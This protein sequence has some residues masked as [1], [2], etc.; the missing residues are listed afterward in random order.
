MI[1]TYEK[2]SLF[3]RYMI[4]GLSASCTELAVLFVLTEYA[5]FKY[6][7]SLVVAV[8][9]SFS[10][11]FL[12]QKYFA[13]K[14]PGVHKIKREL[15]VYSMLYLFTVGSN[16]LLLY[17]AVEAI[18]LPYMISQVGIIIILACISF[19]VYKKW[20]FPKGVGEKVEQPIKASLTH[21]PRQ[22]L[23][24]YYGRFP[25][26]KAASLFAAKSAESFADRGMPTTLIV[27]GG[28]GYKAAQSIEDPFVYFGV[29][30]NLT[31]Q[32]IKALRLA[33]LLGSSYRILSRAAFLMAYLSYAL[34]AVL[35]LLKEQRAGRVH[36]TTILYSNEWLVL[37]FLSFF[38]EGTLLYEMHDFPGSSISVFRLCLRRIPL[39]LIHNSWKAHEAE[40][41][42]GIQ[43]DA[44]CIRSNPADV[45]AFDIAMSKEEARNRLNLPVDAYTVV[46]T[47][48]LF[49][50]KGVYTA[51]EAA[52]LRPNYFFVFVGGSPHDV[53]LFKKKAA[54]HAAGNL[55]NKNVRVVGHKPHQEMP[56]WQ[57]AADVLILPNT[58]KEKISTHY[59]SPMKLF[60]YMASKRPIIASR[61]PSVLEIV[62]D[63]QAFLIEPDAPEAMA[64]MLD[65]VAHSASAER[66]DTIIAQA[67]ER[68]Q[69]NTWI[70][71][72]EEIKHFIESHVV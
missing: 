50:W 63:T 62:D 29:K 64:K 47:G 68:V 13:F 7:I 45:E 6:L 59:T 67:F 55:L 33:S 49:N 35:Y 27:P 54:E 53:T 71:R 66:R 37:F 10:L 14:Q 52:A 9:I 11:R 69:H 18:H 1:F 65:T 31:I 23:L 56:L 57:K 38:H 17:G 15:P 39:F 41:L 26:E 12:L 30:R 25:G 51:L 36:K 24:F 4:A 48:H 20:I 32:R 61:I 3:T 22:L 42:F 34:S 60:E 72:A 21:E 16:S 70:N 43:K 19:F 58:G 46:Y 28:P 2:I 5:G 8:S 40:R 44:I